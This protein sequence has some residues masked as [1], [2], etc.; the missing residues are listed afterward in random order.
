MRFDY[1]DP[2]DDYDYDEQSYDYCDRSSQQAEEDQNSERF[3]TASWQPRDAVLN[4]QTTPY[5]AADT[6]H[7]D[8]RRG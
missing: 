3:R 8:R 6:R 4:W 5:S 2:D 1:D 7:P